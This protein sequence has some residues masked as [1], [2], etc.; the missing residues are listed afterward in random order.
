MFQQCDI[1]GGDI[2]HGVCFNCGLP[3]ED[4]LT[5]T[6]IEEKIVNVNEEEDAKLFSEWIQQHAYKFGINPNMK[7]LF[8][9]WKTIGHLPCRNG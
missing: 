4:Y 9:F 5:D 2:E 8:L 6:D 7:A 3:A 1:C